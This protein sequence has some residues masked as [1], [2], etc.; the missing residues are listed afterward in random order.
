[1]LDLPETKFKKAKLAQIPAYKE[2]QTKCKRHTLDPRIAKLDQIEKD[3]ADVALQTE[4]DEK[5]QNLTLRHGVNQSL[6]NKSSVTLISSFFHTHLCTYSLI[7]LVFH[8]AHHPILE[9]FRLIPSLF[10]SILGFQKP[11]KINIIGPN[12]LHYLLIT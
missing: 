6:I 12:I 2:I 8:I 3:G 4:W 9:F 1:M 10:S 5:I 7:G 11:S